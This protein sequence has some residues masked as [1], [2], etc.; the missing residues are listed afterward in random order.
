MER[1]HCED[2]RLDG[3]RVLFDPE[4]RIG[5]SLKGLIWLRIETGGGLL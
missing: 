1:E 4:D 5:G 3:R 2:L